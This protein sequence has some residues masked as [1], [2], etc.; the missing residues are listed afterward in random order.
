MNAWDDTFQTPR[1]SLLQPLL[2]ADEVDKGSQRSTER[3]VLDAYYNV[4]RLWADAHP[5]IPGGRLDGKFEVTSAARQPV[6]ELIIKTQVIRRRIEQRQE[7]ASRTSADERPIPA[8]TPL[9]IVPLERVGFPTEQAT[10]THRLPGGETIRPCGTCGAEGHLACSPCAQTG[11]VACSSCSGAKRTVCDSCAGAGR[12]RLANGIIV[13]CGSC[14]A[15]GFRTCTACGPDGQVT[16]SRCSG[17][18]F[19]TCSQCAGYGRLCTY[20]VL[21][22]EVATEST[23]VTQ[24]AEPWDVD[25]DTLCTDMEPLWS[26]DVSLGFPS[27]GQ[28]AIFDVETYSPEVSPSVV[29]H[30]RQAIS[31][32]LARG[33]VQGSRAETARALRLQMRGCYVH[34]VGYRLDGGKTENPLYIG[35]LQN[36]MAPGAL[37]ELC[38]T[39]TAWVQ[40]PFH[41]LMRSI[42]AVETQGPSSAFRKRLQNNGGLVHV[43]DAKVIVAEAIESQAFQLT[44]VDEGYEI[45]AKSRKLALIE[46]THDQARG[47]L[48]VSLLCPLGQALRERFVDALRFNGVV[49]FGRIGL[50]TDPNSGTLGFT[51]F[52]IRPY[53]EL[54]KDTYGVILDYLLNTVRP[55]AISKLIG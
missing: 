39:S 25:L 49:T 54:E 29:M 1:I 27:N 50:V 51:L 47:E 20:H 8:G 28:A 9:R 12:Q 19:N 7:P 53:S 22:S 35:G 26:E 21:V 17:Q 32:A 43:L 52:D 4:V 34:K 33:T 42:G 38:R 37:H 44:V 23:R 31:A 14:L 18:G 15:T 11:R 5:E 46:L 16:C 36:R 13:N 3:L 48:I 40:R 45:H 55:N 6:Y 30:V 2:G 24:Q 10:N 41:W